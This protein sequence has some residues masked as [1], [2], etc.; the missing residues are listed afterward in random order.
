MSK[1]NLKRL[2]HK[3]KHDARARKH[4]V[5]GEFLDVLADLKYLDCSR[6]FCIALPQ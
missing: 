3:P 2:P 4:D 5:I 6:S 1:E